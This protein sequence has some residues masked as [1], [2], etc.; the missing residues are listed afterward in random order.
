V[1]RLLTFDLSELKR[2]QAGGKGVILM[3][4]D[5][6]EKLLSAIPFGSAGLQMDGLGRTG[7]PTSVNISYKTLLDFKAQRAR[8]GHL[9]EPKLKD[10]ILKP[11]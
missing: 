7:K 5:P 8:K 1:I 3:D 10:G 6:K 9:I 4:L 11:I 2:L